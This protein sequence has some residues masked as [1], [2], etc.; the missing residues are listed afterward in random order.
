[1]QDILPGYNLKLN[2]SSNIPGHSF[3]MTSDLRRRRLVV[4]NKCFPLFLNVKY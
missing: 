4:K 1:M 3:G 2:N